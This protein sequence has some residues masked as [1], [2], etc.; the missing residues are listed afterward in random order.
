MIT[1]ERAKEIIEQVVYITIGGTSNDGQPW[2]TPVFS[3]YDDSYNFFWGS[4]VNSQHSQNI[5][6]N[7]KVFL[8]IYDSTIPAGEGEGVYIKAHAA[9][10]TDTKELAFAHSLLQKRRPVPYWSLD[11][12]QP[13]SPVRLFKAVPEQVWV[14]GEGEA[15]GTYIDIRQ[16]IKL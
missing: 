3:A 10:I 7:G 6:A 2:N 1:S 8:V 16:E 5:S 12:V 13:T 9:E 14:N 4:H 11:Q 15:D